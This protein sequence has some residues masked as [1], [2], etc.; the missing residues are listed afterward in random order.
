MESKQG[1]SFTEFTYQ[2]LQAYDFYKLHTLH[3][4]NI[5]LG[6]SDQW[7]NVMAGLELISRLGDATPGQHNNREETAFGITTPRLAQRSIDQRVRFL[8]GNG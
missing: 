8:S 3:K 5:Q 4:C 2:L 7:G 6:G 1:I